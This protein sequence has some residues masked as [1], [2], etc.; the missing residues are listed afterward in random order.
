MDSTRRK[1]S[2]YGGLLEYGKSGGGRWRFSQGLEWRSPELE[3][4]ELGYMQLADEIDQY[5]TVSYEVNTPVSIFR[6]YVL[7]ASQ[8]FNWDYG[9]RNTLIQSFGYFTTNFTNF[10][11]FHTHLRYDHQLRDSRML[12]GGPAVKYK[13]L[14]QHHFRV[15]SDSRKIL[16]GYIN[17]LYDWS[18]ED[19]LHAYEIQP[20]LT[21]RINQAFTISGSMGYGKNENHMQYIST[22]PIN[23]KN[24]Y[25]LGFIN[26]E[27]IDI[28]L[29]INYLLTPE[30]SIQYYGQPF[31]SQGRFSQ[32][33]ET[34]MPDA[35]HASDRFHQFNDNEW[36]YDAVNNRYIFYS[37]PDYAINNP[38]FNLLSYRSNLVLR[39][40]YKTGSTLYFVWS[41]NRW[42]SQYQLDNLFNTQPN[43]ILLLKASYLLFY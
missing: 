26:Q 27:T 12:R 4:N 14:W 40:E 41:Q 29:R 43:N 13:S 2:G 39:W 34:T 42:D 9:L 22:V 5:T 19:L 25:V 16:N 30:L 6:D 24:N 38:D 20:G 21:V 8:I 32:F 7:Y 18:A 1:L 36:Q 11:S 37:N 35:E 10:W 28:T 31:Y 33:K 15:D 3:V 23:N 17:I